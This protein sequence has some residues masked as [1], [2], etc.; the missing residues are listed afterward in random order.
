[1]WKNTDCQDVNTKN[2]VKKVLKQTYQIY[3]EKYLPAI[4]VDMD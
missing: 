2:H 3:S 4:L 1:M